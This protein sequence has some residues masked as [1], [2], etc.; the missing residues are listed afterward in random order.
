[1]CFLFV[2]SLSKSRKRFSTNEFYMVRIDNQNRYGYLPLSFSDMMRLIIS[3]G[4]VWLY[5]YKIACLFAIPW[6]S[7]TKNSTEQIQYYF[8]FFF[9]PPKTL[10]CSPENNQMNGFSHSIFPPFLYVCGSD[11]NFCFLLL[12]T[13]SFVRGLFPEVLSSNTKTRPTT[14]GS[15][16]KSQANQLVEALMKCT[17]HYIR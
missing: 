5:F 6:P 9:S 3:N 7:G 4:A 1:M 8:F 16:I 10:F 13:S 11:F 12:W 17:P 15:K 2:F 14:A